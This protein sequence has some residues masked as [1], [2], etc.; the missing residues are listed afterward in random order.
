M[1]SS[2]ARAVLLILAVTLAAGALRLWS[3]GEPDR[4][5]FDEVY[6]ASDGCLSSGRDFRECGLEDDA[7]RSWV[8]PPLGKALIA[9]GIDAF[10]NRALGWRVASAVAGTATVALIGILAYLLFRRAVWAGVASL[11][12]ATESL[13]FVQ[14]R[15]SML[16]VFLAFFV[17][18][19]F[20]LLVADR[21][22]AERR[23]LA[24]PQPPHGEGWDAPGRSHGED[25]PTPAGLGGVRPVRLLAGAAFG[26]AVA[27]KWSGVLALAGALILSGAW[28]ISA[29]RAGRRAGVDPDRLR[30]AFWADTA[31]VAL[32]LVIVPAVVYL[33][34]WLPWLSGRG[35]SLPQWW[36]HHLAMADYHLNLDTVKEGGEPIHPY[37]SP[38]WKWFLLL[39]PV[40]Y[41][42]R[43]DPRCCAEILGIGNPLLFWGA[44]VVIP[45]LAVAWRQRLDWRAGAAL[46]PIL[47]QYL[48]WLAVTRPL[49]LFYMTPVTPFLAL[50]MA[51]V[52]RDLVVAPVSRRRVA[53][54]AVAA[55]VLVSVGLFAFFWP[56]LT[57]HQVSQAAWGR[58]IWLDGW[59]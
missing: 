58:R 42:W 3:L 25:E 19:G 13:H 17:V 36:R 31:S 15:I 23:A 55:V 59:V 45:Y 6:Y 50:G 11:L 29:L 20:V 28:A 40:A 34:A 10:G 2:L 39:R 52:L 47:S 51:Y 8:H 37:M 16:D 27:V 33:A 43:G 41:Y 53:V 56:V 32:G 7:E 22:V 21:R 30:R 57:G 38:A 49:F 5:V 46:V 4:K 24:M 35:W 18:L 44:L 26:G 54:P 1:R 12:L 14:S 48:P 9:L